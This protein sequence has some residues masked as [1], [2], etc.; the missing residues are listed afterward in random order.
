MNIWRIAALGVA[1]ALAAMLVAS[2]VWAHQAASGWQYDLA[3]CHD[4]DCQALPEGAVKITPQ[5]Y[6]WDGETFPFASPKV[7]VSG[8][9]LYHGCKI[10][11]SGYRPCLYVPPMG[12]QLQKGAGHG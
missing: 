5:G 7:R 9:S 12:A 4:E 11:G 2:V 3:C 8:D 6:V 10:E 1:V